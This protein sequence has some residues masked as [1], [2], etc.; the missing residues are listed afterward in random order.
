MTNSNS[1]KSLI[2]INNREFE[3]KNKTIIYLTPLIYYVGIM[4]LAT[5]LYVMQIISSNIYIYILVFGCV[6]YIMR[7]IYILYTH[8]SFTQKTRQFMDFFQKSQIVAEIFGFQATKSQF[9]SEP[10][11][12]V[13]K[14]TNI[15]VKV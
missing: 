11:L 15:F 13:L 12:F 5:F 10:P 9:S 4:F 2:N 6:L 1:Y 7:V 14:V 8:R 3:N